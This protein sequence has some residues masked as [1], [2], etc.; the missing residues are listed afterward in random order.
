VDVEIHDGIFLGLVQVQECPI[1]GQLA[2]VFSGKIWI[3][4]RA[5]QF[6]ALLRKA[7]GVRSVSSLKKL[8]K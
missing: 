7:A 8:Q 1:K 2:I 4:F 6:P 3:S 5:D